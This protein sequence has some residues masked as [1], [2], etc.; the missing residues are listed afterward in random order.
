MTPKTLTEKELGEL[1]ELVRPRL[2][3]KRYAHTRA[4]EREAVRLGEIYLPEKIPSLRAS[5]LLHDITKKED[6][7][8]QLQICAE[9]GIIPEETD[10]LSPSV[11]HAITGA[12]VAG[13]DF[14]G[15]VDAEILSGIRWHT[16]GRAGMTLFESIVYLADYIEETR[17]FDDCIRL[18]R[19]F[20]GR[21]GKG[22]DPCAVLC[23]IMIESFDLTIGGLLR[24]GAPIAGDTVAARNDFILKRHLRRTERNAET[25][26]QNRQ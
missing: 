18:R 15:Y 8:K 24:D 7:E 23:D 4:V 16:T 3:E 13:R 22:E 2:T 17:T 14:P 1:A 19:D 20:Y 25:G 26:G 5:A 11:F 12:A 10:R 21:L 9:F 6:P